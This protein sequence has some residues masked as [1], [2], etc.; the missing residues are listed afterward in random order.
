MSTENLKY[1]KEHEWVSN[2]TDA[3]VGITEHAAELLGDV[4]FV[5]LPEVGLSCK[6][7]DVIATIES[8]KT[9]SDIYAPVDG[10]IIEVNQTLADEPQLI[11]DSPLADGWIFKI[12]IT[13]GQENLIS[14]QEYADLIKD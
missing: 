5:E 4:V 8:V 3:T 2:D 12:K 14:A 10:E 7:G 9:A 13:G 11:N 1:T 6:A